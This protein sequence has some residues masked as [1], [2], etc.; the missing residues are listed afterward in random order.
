M[1]KI[2]HLVALAVCALAGITTQ[3]QTVTKPTAST[4]DNYTYY[5]LKA[6]GTDFVLAPIYKNNG[7]SGWNVF[8]GTKNVANAAYLVFEDVEG[9]ESKAVNEKEY[10]IRSLDNGHYLS[11]AG[12][13][14]NSILKISATKSDEEKWAIVTSDDL[15]NAVAIV[16]ADTKNNENTTRLAISGGS[17]GGKWTLLQAMSTPSAKVYWD[18]TQATNTDAR[19]N[20]LKNTFNTKYSEVKNA[21][22]PFLDKVGGITTAS[23]NETDLNKTYSQHY[24]GTTDA[25]VFEMMRAKIGYDLNGFGSNVQMICPESGKVY[26]VYNA[27]GTVT[28]EQETKRWIVCTSNN[29]S[30]TKTAWQSED[31]TDASGYWVAQNFADG[32]RLVNLAGGGAMGNFIDLTLSDNGLKMG[33]DWG[34]KLGAVT[35][36]VYEQET[37]GKKRT[38]CT[39]GNTSAPTFGFYTKEANEALSKLRNA[40][41]STDFVFEEVNDKQFTA[42]ITA[43]SNG[44]FGTLCLPF[45]AKMPE[46][47][48]AY[49][50]KAN[51]DGSS[52]ALSALNL[53]DKVLPAHTPVLLSSETAGEKSFTP[54]APA[55]DANCASSIETGLQGVCAAKAVT[56][57]NAYILALEGEAGSALGFYQ[58]N[59]SSNLV[60]ANKAYYVPAAGGAQFLSL[61]LGEATGIESVTGNEAAKAPVYD[62]SGRRVQNPVKG[63]LYIQGGKKYI[64]K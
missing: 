40:E 48:T 52:L 53:T 31:P 14:N 13:F 46:G 63:S 57:A 22:T 56:T 12:L 60:N 24:S 20:A 45:A 32:I 15:T 39:S 6:N 10:Y 5:Q 21:L 2:T 64:S 11:H 58:L 9:N 29:G 17:D 19:K 41:N 44:N 7:L 38:Y 27:V 23:W 61:D 49:G 30:M 35:L 18:M 28:A 34:L 3:A 43:G 62:L 25:D 8:G 26:R 59:Q 33:W 36:V 54:A 55:A 16:T 1:R 51:D 4:A 47:V 42:N 37:T 50:V